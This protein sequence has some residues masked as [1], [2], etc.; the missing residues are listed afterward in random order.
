MKKIKV[1]QMFVANAKGGRTQYMLN[2]WK[3]IDRNLFQFDFATLSP[4]LDFAENLEAEGCKIHYVSCYAE[5]DYDRFVSEIDKIFEQKYDVIHIHSSFWRSTT[6]EERAKAVGIKNIIIHAHN[7]GI[8]GALSEEEA[9]VLEQ[10]HF[11]IRESISD[12]LATRYLACSEEAAEWMYGTSISADKIKVLRN[13]ID[14]NKYRYNEKARH[15]V[16][17]K[18]G[19]DDKYVLGNVGRFVYQKNHE[20]LI[21]VFGEVCKHNDNTV[22]LLIGIGE[23][24]DKIK[25]KV[26]H[27]GLEE[28]VRF[29]G[30]RN[31]VD[32]ILQ[33]MDLFLLPS[34]FDG[35]PLSLLEAQAAA[36]PCIAGN[37][38][39]NAALCERT[40]II[41]LNIDKWVQ[42]I[43]KEIIRKDRSY[44]DEEKLKLHDINIQI[45]ELEKIYREGELDAYYI[46]GT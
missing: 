36:L 40:Q 29:L 42:A 7:F 13:G 35:F 8:G 22:L 14:L 41:E 45:K 39:P 1:L 24:Q 12:D 32:Q 38:P 26:K 28:K 37:V 10:R 20:F 44:I 19:V 17:A 18:L 46:S 11:R 16:R 27:L 33:G 25:T 34:R 21:D 2:A 15:D 23:L 30:A 43:D 4:K 6:I 3:H 31:D 9:M 5:D